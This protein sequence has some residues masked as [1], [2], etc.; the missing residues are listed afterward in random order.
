VTR[1]A[2]LPNDRAVADAAARAIR[3]L[4]QCCDGY[5]RVPAADALIAADAAQHGG[6]TYSDRDEQFD[7]VAEVL[8]FQ[9]IVAPR[10]VEPGLNVAI[11]RPVPRKP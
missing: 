7:H 6:L 4:G 3:E 1:Y 5:Q 10:A 8:R 9:S 2:S 11:E